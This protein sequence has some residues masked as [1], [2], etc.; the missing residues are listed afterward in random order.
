MT[1]A[2]LI[3]WPFSRRPPFPGEFLHAAEQCNR[4]ATFRLAEPLLP[5]A[6]LKK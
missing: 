1:A 2:V 5:L 6:K 3:S 4:P